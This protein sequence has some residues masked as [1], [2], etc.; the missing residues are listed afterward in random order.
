MCNVYHARL[1]CVESI[2][3]ITN[4]LGTHRQFFGIYNS[5]S[6]DK[7]FLLCESCIVP[8]NFIFWSHYGLRLWSSVEIGHPV[9]LSWYDYITN[10][11]PNRASCRQ[12]KSMDGMII[13]FPF[14]KRPRAR[15]KTSPWS[16]AAY[17]FGNCVGGWGWGMERWGVCDA[18]CVCVCERE[19][20]EWVWVGV[21][22]CARARCKIPWPLGVF[23]QPL[24]SNW[25]TFF[26]F[27]SMPSCT[28]NIDSVNFRHYL[29]ELWEIL[30][31]LIYVSFKLRFV[32]TCSVIACESYCHCTP[33]MVSQLWRLTSTPLPLNSYMA[34]VGHNKLDRFD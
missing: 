18:V 19:R 34:P 13:S 23:L 27:I 29:N 24:I 6:P 32:I 17:L 2:L 1:P 3:T 33:V 15:H 25:Q 20:E 7:I 12:T 26:G 11:I 22:V 21:C 4:H 8:G 30:I 14:H 16:L 28:E 9:I 5:C 31:E 10:R